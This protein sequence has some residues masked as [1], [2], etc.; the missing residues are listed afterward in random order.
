MKNPTVVVTDVPGHGVG[1]ERDVL[2]DVGATVVDGSDM[3]D[4]GLTQVLQGAAGILTCFRHVTADHIRSAPDLRVIGRYGVGV[5]NIAVDAA[6][7]RG[8]PVANV[9]DYCVDEVA[10]HALALTLSLTRG[11]A[12]YDRSV[13]N[14]TWELAVAAPLRR[15]SSLVLGVIGF[16]RI[17]QNLAHKAA[18]LGFQVH[19]C[20]RHAAEQ[21]S[22]DR[23]VS[24]SFEDVLGT[25]DVVSLHLPLN[26]STHHLIGRPE[27]ERMKRSAFSSTPR[28]VRSSTRARSSMRCVEG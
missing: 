9:P 21:A 26:A 6:T 20:D 15:T 18:A 22:H 10:D 23:F 28:E 25:A 16:G 5:D 14:G 3:D 27:L 17:G 1:P 12:A 4:A 11:V 2:A 7:E 24:A 13:R 19:V 8:I